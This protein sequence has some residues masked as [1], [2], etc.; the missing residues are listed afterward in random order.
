MKGSK[1]LSKFFKDEK[2]SLL[3]KENALLLCSN[4]II[5][6]LIGKR[7]D[8]RFRVSAQTKSIVKISLQ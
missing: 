8:N 7:L 3:D 2:Y 4:N 5:V 1:K 6:W